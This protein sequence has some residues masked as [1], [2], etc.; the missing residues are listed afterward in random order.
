MNL[1]QL[2][3]LDERGEVSLTNCSVI[4]S[5]ALLCIPLF[6]PGM[7]VLSLAVSLTSYQIK[8][9]LAEKNRPLTNGE[10]LTKR[11]DI[12]ESKITGLSMS[13]RL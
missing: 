5:L 6:P 1:K 12:V 7:A 9:V 2:R 10:E 8:R 11:L 3:I 13:K 4:L